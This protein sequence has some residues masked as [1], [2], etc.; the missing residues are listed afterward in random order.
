M[1]L[2]LVCH[3][4]T[5]R[6]LSSDRL[7]FAPQYPTPIDATQFSLAMGKRLSQQTFNDTTPGPILRDFQVLLDCLG[8][9]GIL[10]TERSQLPAL[11]FLRE[12]NESLSRPTHLSLKRPN[13]KHYAYAIG[14]FWI[15]R[16][17]GFALP[18]TKRK[19]CLFAP[20]DQLQAWTSLCAEEQYFTLLAVW[21]HHANPDALGDRGPYAIQRCLDLFQQL[22]QD[23][24]PLQVIDCEPRNQKQ[25]FD[26]FPALYNLALLDGFGLVHL[27]TVEPAPGRAWSIRSI[28]L[29]EWGEAILTALE[30]MYPPEARWKM[31]SFH[32]PFHD[33][34]PD[35][36]PLTSSSV[37]FT[38][39]SEEYQL[40]EQL[41]GMVEAQIENTDGGSEDVDEAALLASL[42]ALMQDNPERMEVMQSLLMKAVEENQ[43]DFA[44]IRRR[45]TIGGE[46]ELLADLD[47][48]YDS[49]REFVPNLSQTLTLAIPEFNP[50]I[51]VFK[52][53]VGKAWRRLAIPGVWTLEGVAGII[54]EAFEF[55]DIDHL[56]AFNFLSHSGCPVSVVH[57]YAEFGVAKAHEVRVGDLPIV[58]GIQIDFNFDFG[59]NWHFDLLLESIE[60]IDEATMREPNV[61]RIGSQGKAPEQYLD[62]EDW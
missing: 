10:V 51:F 34:R 5:L 42:Q 3:C 13:Q 37:P 60:P 6:H 52:V 12:F 41:Q 58:P 30:T 53:A 17:M 54:L 7:M 35:E 9:D 39:D 47:L 28:A 2:S 27:E 62:D 61:E 59:D 44:A 45:L 46:S 48:Y 25:R 38:P 1:G 32:D 16:S 31:L 36:S 18:N 20:P 57:E 15:A 23:P 55:E 22:K 26:Y 24:Q 49:F 11:K 4:S 50:N 29:T 8:S 56:Y 21:M 40:L 33:P 14:L 19:N 43:A